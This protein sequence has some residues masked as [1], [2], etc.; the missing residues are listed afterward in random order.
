MKDNEVHIGLN[1]AEL[2]DFFGYQLGKLHE[3]PPEKSPKV[4]NDDYI[5]YGID[6]SQLMIEYYT[7]NK[8]RLES[9]RALTLLMKQEGWSEHDVSDHTIKTN[10]FYIHF[11]GTQDE[12]VDLL[13]KTKQK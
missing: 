4:K 7:E 6:K 11:I 12:F 9:V 1:K 10:D 3:P 13:L 5:Q 2:R 8:L